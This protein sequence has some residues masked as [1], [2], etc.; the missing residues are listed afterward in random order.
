[1]PNYMEVRVE[2]NNDLASGLKEALKPI[3]VKDKTQLN[4]K[5]GNVA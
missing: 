5:G 4:L 3:S 2:K 1:M